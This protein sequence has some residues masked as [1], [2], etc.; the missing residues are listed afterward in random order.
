MIFMYSV[1]YDIKYV[2]SV[3]VIQGIYITCHEIK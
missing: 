3:K 2:L 1:K